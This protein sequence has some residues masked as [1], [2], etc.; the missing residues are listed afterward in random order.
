[1]IPLYFVQLVLLTAFCVTF[2]GIISIDYDEAIE[3]DRF[4]SRLPA[5]YRHLDSPY[6]NGRDD[7]RTY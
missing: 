2:F 5:E 6:I 1:M 7:T 3:T 4:R